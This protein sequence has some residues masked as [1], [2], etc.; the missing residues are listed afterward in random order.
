[1]RDPFL[2]RL[3]DLL[4]QI[5]PGQDIP[6][7]GQKIID[8]F[9]PEGKARRKKARAPSNNFWSEK[10]TLVITY[11]NSIQDGV[12]K[13]LDLLRDFLTRQL[14]GVTNGV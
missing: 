10:D 7:L 6:V 14:K 12:H 2:I 8:A 3:H 1:M 11:G 9:W 4:E 5:Y 13:P